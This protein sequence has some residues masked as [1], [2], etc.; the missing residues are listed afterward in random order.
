MDGSVSV[1]ERAGRDR[2]GRFV[3]GVSGNP[4]GKR[5]GALNRM[6]RLK[7]ALDADESGAVARVVI[8]RALAGDMVAAR[9]CLGLIV[10]KPRSR[11]I[12]LDLPECQDIDGIVGAFRGDGGGD[13][14]GGDHAGRGADGH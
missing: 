8:D 13:G 4:A 1:A 9:F 6:T 2:G 5:K 10:P 12:E 14:G 11:P 3:A 7:L